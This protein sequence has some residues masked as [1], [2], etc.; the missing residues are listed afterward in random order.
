MVVC[1]PAKGA[2]AVVRERWAQHRHASWGVLCSV[3]AARPQRKG[4]MAQGT[5][6]SALPCSEESEFSFHL[7]PSGHCAGLLVKVYLV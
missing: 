7:G 3:G 1:A 6:I 5:V 4:E 2:G